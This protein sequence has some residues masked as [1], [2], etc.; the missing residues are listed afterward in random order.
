MPDLLHVVPV[1]DDSILDGVLQGEDSSLALGLISHVGVLLS[2]SDH[3][4]L[5]TGSSHDGGEHGSQSVVP[6]EASL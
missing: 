4:A 2:H 3:D 6:G 5:M 1:G